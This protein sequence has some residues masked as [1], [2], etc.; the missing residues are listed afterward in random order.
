[1]TESKQNP[2]SLSTESK[3]FSRYEE[4]IQ[5]VGRLLDGIKRHRI[6]LAVTAATVIVLVLGFLFMI[7][8]F[9]G[10][11]KCEDFVYGNEPQCAA[12]AFLSDTSYQ[13]APVDGEA[14][15]SDTTPI[16]PGQY[17]IRA[18][19]KNGF[20]MPKYSEVMT[21]TLLKRELRIRIDA[22]SVVYGDSVLDAAEAHTK[23][24]GLAEG[25][26]VAALEYTIVE[27][28]AGKYTASVKSVRIV[29]GAGEEV[30]G[31][32]SIT[33]AYGLFSV[34]P[35]PITVSAKDAQKV[36]DGKQWTAGTAELTGGTLAYE[37]SLRVTFSSAPAEAGAY[38]LVPDCVI[39][40]GEG[41][42]VTVWYRITVQ[43]GTLTVLPRPIKVSTGGGE[44]VYDATPL[45][46]S[47]WSMIEGEL[48]AG[49]TL[50][51]ETTGSQTAAGESLNTIKLTVLDASG[52]DVS[53]NYVLSTRPGKLTVT[54]ITLK[55][56]TD[57]REKV[58]D[59]EFMREGGC[60]LIEGN[61]L[62]GHTLTFHTTGWQMEAGSSPN[63]LSV[64]VK[65]KNGT[66]V[67]ADGYRIE[68]EYGM[69]TVTR[70][71]ITLTSGS[72]EKLYDG[73]PLTCPIY[74]ITSGSMPVSS[75]EDDVRWTNFTGSQ[76]EVGSS[77]NTFTVEITNKLGDVRTS[78]YDITYIY[79]ILTVHENPNP[80]ETGG[81]GGGG[82]SGGYAETGI[83]KHDQGVQIGY[84]DPGVEILYAKVQ[85]LERVNSAT[86]IY[87]RDAS[88]GA[89][90][91]KG[92][93][94]ANRYISSGISPSLFVGRSLEASGQ[95]AASMRIQR[96]NG[97]PMIV[98]YYLANSNLLNAVN[99]DCYFE[100]GFLSYELDYFAGGNYRKMERLTVAQKDIEREENYREF[101]YQEYLQIPEST[102]RELLA[103]AEKM[104]VTSGSATLA[105][106]IQGVISNAAVYNPNGKAY[107][108]NVDVA[109][110]FL[111]VAKEGVC[112]H[113]ATAAT[114]MYRAFGIPARYTVG[115]VDTVRNGMTTDLT[116]G[117]AHAWVEIYVDGLGWVP[118]EVTGNVMAVDGRTELRIQA[119]SV[120]KY[121]DGEPF[122]SA[123]LNQYGI[124]SGSLREGDRLEITCRL[125]E[126]SSYPG[127]Y[128][129]KIVKY[130][131]YDE[132][133][134]NVA[135][136]YYNIHLYSGKAKILP[137]K[138]TVTIGSASK[139]FDGLPLSCTEYWISE[140][141][142]APGE[143]MTV[144][145]LSSLVEPGFTDNT[146]SE[147]AIWSKTLSGGRIDVSFCYEI[148][149][150]PGY[151]KITEEE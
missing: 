81:G 121:Y 108:D 50:V 58:Y 109:V 29:N 60:R 20:G 127:E 56:E 68:V 11:A 3:R 93:E 100:G 15:W 31:C 37:D 128:I 143:K 59:G 61:V 91:G 96:M 95:N 28:E 8:T 43:E 18:V 6:A 146:A 77:A 110:Y 55:F 120:T 42:D 40:N 86:P 126:N 87:F 2:Y 85:G 4:R 149:V 34:T 136:D 147:L 90:T 106:D 72:D 38:D 65:D 64:T 123:D 51:G 27:D 115:F 99:Y 101:V 49:H 24:E 26:S 47:E 1:M 117:D 84:P 92:W 9:I 139:V 89:Y 71:P 150:K 30:T 104:G 21:V 76:T 125:S 131:I 39:M 116:S 23:A 148:T 103:W 69:L 119:Y 142:L 7:G 44:K 70:R 73:T 62:K 33:T 151:L 32:Y 67:T 98:P 130:A 19:S 54:P 140:G 105:E 135:A 63:T 36:Y 41:E 145:I 46:N 35:R 22:A 144:E 45:T 57:S 75:S 97:C 141:S 88:Y 122:G 137:R 134:K 16:L 114:L 14:V 111:T 132:N 80:P 112:Q 12:K 133:G 129:N 79:G 124:L 74:S 82:G 138:I 66:D 10:T 118:M 52:V 94:T 113:F 25:D 107:P 83:A 48:V 17:R 102:K 53:V 78:N 5:A 13:F